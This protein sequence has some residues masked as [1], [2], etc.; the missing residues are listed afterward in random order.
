MRLFFLNS[1]K[2][3]HF[4]KT[5]IDASISMCRLHLSDP[6]RAFQYRLRE[7][8]IEQHDTPQQPMTGHIQKRGG[9]THHQAEDN[10]ESSKYQV[11]DRIVKSA[12][13]I[14]SRHR[15]A[16]AFCDQTSTEKSR[17]S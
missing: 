1:L 13:K 4:G 17:G 15:E 11:I 9:S 6:D 14:Q 16:P 5:D 12:R 7:E 10:L 2:Y 3:C 8:T